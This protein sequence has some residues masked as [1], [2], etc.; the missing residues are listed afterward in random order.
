MPFNKPTKIMQLS[1]CDED[2][3]DDE[4]EAVQPSE[5]NPSTVAAASDPTAMKKMASGSS[6]DSPDGLA[7]A[8]AGAQG[9]GR[10]GS[11]AASGLR[12]GGSRSGGCKNR[13]KMN[14][15]V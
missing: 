13:K 7:A 6:N 2:D 10:H 3:D 4:A 5:A 8:T 15:G 12:P 9:S 1:V 11:I 14:M